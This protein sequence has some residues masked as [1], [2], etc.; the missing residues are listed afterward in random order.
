[1]G[2]RFFLAER[3]YS[4]WS[5]SILRYRVSFYREVFKKI[6]KNLSYG[7]VNVMG[8]DAFTKRSIGIKKR[9]ES[10]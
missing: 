7:N 2:E 3:L 1:M 5:E 10:N 8:I 4:R 9:C 6:G